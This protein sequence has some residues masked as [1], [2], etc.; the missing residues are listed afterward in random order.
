MACIRRQE[1][2]WYLLVEVGFGELQRVEQGI[3]SSQFDIVT[4]LLLPHALDD[5]SQD[6]V[7]VFLQLLRVL[8]GPQPG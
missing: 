4:G 3:G 2:V 6:L 1:V 8:K 7:G 5:G